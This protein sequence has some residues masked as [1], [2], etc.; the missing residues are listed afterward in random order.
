MS[1]LS[2]SEWYGNPTDMMIPLFAVERFN[3][4]FSTYFEAVQYTGCRPAAFQL[5]DFQFR[6]ANVSAESV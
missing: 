4:F 3:Q 1:R 5:R 2:L 6:P